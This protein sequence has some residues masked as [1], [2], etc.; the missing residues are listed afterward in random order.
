MACDDVQIDWGYTGSGAPENWG[1]LSDEFRPCRDGVQQSPVNITGYAPGDGPSLAFQYAGSAVSSHNTGKSAYL[2]YGPGNSID[3]GGHQYDLLWIHYH[4]PG[5]HL[6]D[7]ESFAA[8]LHLV[9][10]DSAG[11]LA[12]VGLLFRSG[13]ASPL[14]QALLDAAPGAG[15]TVQLE[16]GIEAAA[17]IP[18]DSGYFGY[19]GSL[20]TPPC[21]EGVRWIVMQAIGTVS[22]EQ[23]AGLQALSG[24]ANN[25]P[26][27][28]VGARSITRVAA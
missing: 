26:I 14:V 13:V 16:S 24:G 7:G 23:V 11:S 8:E 12:V 20:T 19:D 25:R 6:V 17:Y 27:Q 28:P 21:T 22:P 18:P 9:H 4:S 10:Q 3:F 5:E 1:D 2:D 15:D